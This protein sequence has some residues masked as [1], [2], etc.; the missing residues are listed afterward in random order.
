LNL[1]NACPKPIPQTSVGVLEIN[2]K[3][4]TPLRRMV[5]CVDVAWTH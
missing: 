4:E 1:A 2:L 5:R 3:F